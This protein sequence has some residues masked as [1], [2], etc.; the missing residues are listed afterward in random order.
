MG[1]VQDMLKHSCSLL[2]ESSSVVKDALSR[3]DKVLAPPTAFNDSQVNCEPMETTPAPTPVVAK[4]PKVGRG[5][6]SKAE[7]GPPGPLSLFPPKMMPVPV[8]QE[9]MEIRNGV[10]RTYWADK[11]CN[12]VTVD[13][14]VVGPRPSKAVVSSDLST[15]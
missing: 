11:G 2:T 12:Y 9:D 10:W 1:K 5:R 4:K 7:N 6:G 13:S 8:D 14:T 15:Q 3:A